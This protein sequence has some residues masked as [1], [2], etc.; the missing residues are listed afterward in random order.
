MNS[1]RL[2]VAGGWP[3]LPLLLSWTVAPVFA[4]SSVSEPGPGLQAELRI[5]SLLRDGLAAEGLRTRVGWRDGRLALE[6]SAVRLRLPGPVEELRALRLECPDLR[7]SRDRVRCAG[8]RLWAE[9]DGLRLE[10]ARLD[11]A[12]GRTSGAMEIS[13]PWPGLFGAQGELEMG[14]QPER[15]WTVG[16]QLAGLELAPLVGAGLWPE[17]LPV[18]IQAGTADLD[19]QLRADGSLDATLVARGVG[20]SD[21]LGLRAGEGLAGRMTVAGDPGGWDL[22]AA[23]EGGVMFL[24]PWFLDVDE[25]GPLALVLSGLRGGASI[26]SG[27]AVAARLAF[28][29]RLVVSGE[30]LA[31]DPESGIDGHFG[32]RA[33]ELGPAYTTFLMPLLAGTALGELEV[34]GALEGE[35][36]L[37]ASEPRRARARWEDG[38]AED[39]RGRFGLAGARGEL[40]WDAVRGGDPGWLAVE[41]AHLYGLPLSAFEARVRLLP[42]GLELLEATE[43][44]ILDGGLQ[45]RAFELRQTDDGPDVR[46]EGGVRAISLD[47]V[48]EV[49]GWPQFSGRLAGMIPRVRLD[50]GDVSVD[51][52]LL[53]Q[54][55]DG[56]VVLRDVWL[57]DLFGRAPELGLSGEL[58]RLDLELITRAFDLGRV[59]GRLSG[60]V[61]DLRLVDWSP[62]HMDL[63]LQTPEQDP[64]RRRISQRAV[65]NITEL[66]GGL[67]AAASTIFLQVF[68]NFS[69]RRLG[70]RCQLRGEVCTAAGVA[71][72][73]DGGFVLVEGGGLPQ[74]RVIGYNRRVDWPELLERLGRIQEGGSATAAPD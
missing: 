58:Q 9:A 35:L 36:E 47:L 5:E 51:G 30:Q 54:V 22:S 66:G 70:F 64:G 34:S 38:V 6:L 12:W 14:Y 27:S 7:L 62:V 19:L 73:A 48:T 32:I 13:G 68:K 23:L 46:F 4:A 10:D 44:P 21:E 3:L 72:Q 40:N 49:L 41:R 29:D 1:R 71:D 20:F 61:H 15:G 37:R 52:R 65:E 56:D 31:F 53:V 63:L 45:V 28:G 67:Q 50:R 25:Q 57:H 17:P 16:L 2:R 59:E 43:I 26:L 33:G 11:L 69:Y 55:F 60:H 74:I 24:D 42:A 39:R 8:A 18:T